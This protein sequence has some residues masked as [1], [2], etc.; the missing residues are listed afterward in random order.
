MY[1]PKFGITHIYPSV[2]NAKDIV[3]LRYGGLVRSGMP[4]EKAEQ[5]SSS[6]NEEHVEKQLKHLEDY[7]E[8]YLGVIAVGSGDWIGFSNVSEWTIEDH[9]PYCSGIEHFALKSLKR[10]ADNQ[11]L[12]RPLGIH[13]LVVVDDAKQRRDILD[14]LLSR[15]IE[16]AETKEVYTAQYDDAV[17]LRSLYENRFMSASERKVVPD[18]SKHLYK[19]PFPAPEQDYGYKKG[20]A[21]IFR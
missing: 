9:L 6:D 12:G 10:F 17:V 13:E 4:Y 16:M 8:R 14:S 5:M 21:K 7:P 18:D 11:L 20:I 3:D 15:A 1:T 19:R 2:E